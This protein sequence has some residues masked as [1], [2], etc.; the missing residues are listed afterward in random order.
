MQGILVAMQIVGETLNLLKREAE[1]E[2][3]MRRPGGI[4]ITEEQELHRIRR[5]LRTV[6]DAVDAVLTVS[7][8]LAC[9]LSR[10]T[11][12]DVAFWARSGIG[13]CLE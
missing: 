10:V 11:E 7:K 6:P 5:R 1:L 3:G 9:P 13:E 2:G 4:R 12:H 8:A